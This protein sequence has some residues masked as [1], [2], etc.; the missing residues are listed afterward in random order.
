M[1]EEKLLS[2]S[3]SMGIIGKT[4]WLFGLSI[5]SVCKCSQL[6]KKLTEGETTLPLLKFPFLI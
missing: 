6:P 3:L 2:Q 1:K 4:E 5:I